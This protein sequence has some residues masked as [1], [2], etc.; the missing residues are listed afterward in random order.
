M[1]KPNILT[2]VVGLVISIGVVYGYTYV[3]G[4]SWKSSQK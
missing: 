2:L 3:I 4:K 1:K